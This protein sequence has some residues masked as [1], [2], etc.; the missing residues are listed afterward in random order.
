MYC[1]KYIVAVEGQE[2]PA[3]FDMDMKNSHYMLYLIEFKCK[4]D[5]FVVEGNL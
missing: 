4:P 1:G 3:S 2:W 5:N